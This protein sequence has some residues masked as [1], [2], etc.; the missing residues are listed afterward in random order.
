MPSIKK[1][2]KKVENGKRYY[3]VPELI[4]VYEKESLNYEEFENEITMIK[5]KERKWIT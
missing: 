1:Y 5:V 4:K 2:L 3:D